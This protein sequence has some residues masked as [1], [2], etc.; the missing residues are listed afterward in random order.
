MN[1]T[2]KPYDDIPVTQLNVGNIFCSKWGNPPGIVTRVF[3][4]PLTTMSNG[5]PMISFEYEGDLCGKRICDIRP[6][7]TVRVYQ[8]E[9]KDAN[10]E[11]I[12]KYERRGK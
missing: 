5:Y 10:N 2:V 4:D 3:Q 9:L 12:A 7:Q 11:W 6:D 1:R 8:G